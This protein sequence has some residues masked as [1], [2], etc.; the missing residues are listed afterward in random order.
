MSSQVVQMTESI[1][2]EQLKAYSRHIASLGRQIAAEHARVTNWLLHQR[3]LYA[4]GKFCCF[5]IALLA[6]CVHCKQAPT[7]GVLADR[8]ITAKKGKNAKS[9][10]CLLAACQDRCRHLMGCKTVRAHVIQTR[11][12]PCEGELPLPLP[13]PLGSI[14][15]A[16]YA[17]R[18]D[19]LCRWQVCIWH[20]YICVVS[21]TTMCQC[22]RS[23]PGPYRSKACS[24][25]CLFNASF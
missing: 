12:W 23:Y 2:M 5:R 6:V 25:G 16:L 10:R 20:L 18:Q 19:I 24:H 21:A 1:W 11:A 4:L 17:H 15:Q 8:L 9:A 22:C 13:L 14:V 7:N 3:G